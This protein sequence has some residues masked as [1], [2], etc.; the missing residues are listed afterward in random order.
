MGKSGWLLMTISPEDELTITKGHEEQAER[1][2][3]VEN[4]WFP[5]L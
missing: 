5:S 2:P 1:E 4:F 3:K